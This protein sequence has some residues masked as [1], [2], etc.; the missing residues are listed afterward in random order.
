[1]P[2]IDVMGYNPRIDWAVLQERLK[3]ISESSS[4]AVI[5]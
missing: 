2:R 3:R 1:V 5:N 4:D